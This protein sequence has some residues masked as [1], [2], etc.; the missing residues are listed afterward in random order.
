MGLLREGKD[1]RNKGLVWII[2][3]LQELEISIM[4]DMM[5]LGLDEPSKDFVMRLAEKDYQLT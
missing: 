1:T 3:C 4:K 5:P 2:G